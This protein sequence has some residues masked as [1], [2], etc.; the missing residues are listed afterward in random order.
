MG[1]DLLARE[2]KNCQGKVGQNSWDFSLH[3]NWY[4]PFSSQY[5]YLPTCGEFQFTI[6][7]FSSYEKVLFASCISRLKIRLAK[8]AK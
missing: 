8:F 1:C 4:F 7:H 2:F 5:N 6:V 3:K